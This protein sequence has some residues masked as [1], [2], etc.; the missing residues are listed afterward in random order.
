MNPKP[1]PGSVRVALVNLY[2]AVA[3]VMRKDWPALRLMVS[4]LTDALEGVEDVLIVIS[5]AT[6]EC[7]WDGFGLV[8][9]HPGSMDSGADNSAVVARELLAIAAGFDLSSPDLVNA[10]AWRLDAVRSGDRDRA[11]ADIVQ[12]QRLGSEMELVDGAIALLAAIVTRQAR[13]SGL[14]PQR[15]ASDICLAV[16][17]AAGELPQSTPQPH[18]AHNHRRAA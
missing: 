6:L 4:D 15:L 10:A 7:L 5:L 8:E 12:S 3:A 17:L 2:G 16:S 11:A 13:R 9:R 14:S 18:L 1:V